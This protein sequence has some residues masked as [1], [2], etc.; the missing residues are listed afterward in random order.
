MPRGEVGCGRL[1]D[2]VE[3]VGHED[4]GV[5]APRANG[6]GPPKVV[7]QA[8]AVVVISRTMSC[9]PLPWPPTW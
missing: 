4:V 6:G 8:T 5:D 3:V 7:P 9:R 1:E 2:E